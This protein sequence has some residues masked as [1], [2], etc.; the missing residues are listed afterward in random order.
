MKVTEALLSFVGD[1]LQIV[2]NNAY[3]LDPARTG[4]TS[5]Y[6]HS[7]SS[8]TCGQPIYWGAY[9]DNAQTVNH[10]KVIARD[11]ATEEVVSGN[12][13]DWESIAATGERLKVV[14][15]YTAGNFADAETS[16]LLGLENSAKGEICGRILAPVNVGV[17]LYDV[18]EIA[19]LGAGVDGEAFRVLGIKTVY[20][21]GAGKYEQELTLG[22]V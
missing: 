2:G 3:L 15:D 21:P 10:Y 8:E 4:Q 7:A 17:Q 20:Q 9:F 5:F 22:R 12:A 13:Y 18:V 6:Y 1:Y 16:A 11:E 14:Q 19:D